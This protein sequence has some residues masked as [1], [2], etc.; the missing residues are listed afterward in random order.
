MS[1][2]FEDLEV[3]DTIKKAL[4]RAKITNTG[5]LLEKCA[6]P[7][8][9]AETAAISGLEAETLLQLT[10]AADLLRVRNVGI[11]SMRLLQ[12][13]GVE[14]V[15]ALQKQDVATLMQKLSETNGRPKSRL[16]DRLPGPKLVA[17]WVEGAKSLPIVVVC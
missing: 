10:R 8:G 6:K 14:T 3:G 5:H 11:E 1:Y 4:A 16:I 2:S 12:A 13:A 7:K 17:G 9:R 15:K